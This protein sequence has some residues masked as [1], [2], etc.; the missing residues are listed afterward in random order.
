MTPQTDGERPPKK[1]RKKPLALA[2]MFWA[3]IE[4]MCVQ[5]QAYVGCMCVFFTVAWSKTSIFIE[6]QMIPVT[7]HTVPTFRAATFFID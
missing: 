7:K 4:K 5:V 3:D 1:R 6:G 2:I